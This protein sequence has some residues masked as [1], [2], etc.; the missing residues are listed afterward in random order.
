MKSDVKCLV[1]ANCYL[2]GDSVEHGRGFGPARGTILLEVSFCIFF[3]PQ[4]LISPVYLPTTQ[5]ILL[6]SP[7][8]W[9]VAGDHLHIA[10]LL[11]RTIPKMTV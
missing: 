7:L 1:N 6:G 5:I 10:N 2:G 11:V 3:D 8:H 4:S 9:A